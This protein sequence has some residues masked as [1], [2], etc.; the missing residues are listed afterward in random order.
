MPKAIRFHEIGGPEV[1]RFE[2]IAKPE[3]GR[4]EVRLKVQAIGLNRAESM[5]YRG[6]YIYQPKLPAG[7]GYEAS[8]V[9]E[10]V[11]PD[12]DKS[13]IGKSVSTIP[14]FSLNEYGMVGEE[15]IAPIVALAEY[16]ANLSVV[17]S[18][19][20]WMQYVTAY[21]AL[22]GIAGVK[23]GDFVVI[24][25]ASSSVGIAAIEIAKAEGAV[26]IA[27]TRTSQKKAELK[28]LGADHVIATEEEDF[29]AHVQEITGGKGARVIF[30]PVAGPFLEKLADA[31]APGG[32]I[33]Q[34]GAL[35]LQPTPLPLVTI[36]VKGVSVRGYTLMEF[37]RVPEKLA[38]AKKYVY[39]RLADGRFTPRIAKTFPFAQTVEAYKYLESNAQVGKIVVT[40][41]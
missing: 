31:V 5:F 32:I 8:G 11:G 25:A 38:P 7:L 36:L 14:A 9:V 33:F 10:A 15:V 12:A 13:W 39:D 17:E 40:V 29:V 30:D 2:E 18:A 24:S 6:Q 21:G 16:P 37:T 23:K 28:E 35:S 27:T 4:G 19:A 34:Y 26:S 3:P 41:P 20:I 22:I 1:L